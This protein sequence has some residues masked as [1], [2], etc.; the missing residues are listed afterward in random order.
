MVTFRQ[1][2]HSPQDVGRL[3]GHK[4]KYFEQ[5]N[6]LALFCV[7]YVDDGAFPFKNREQLTRGISL[8]Y[9]HFTRFALEMHVGRGE[10][11]SKTKCIFFPPSGFFS[12]K[13]IMP[14]VNGM[15]RKKLSVPKGKN[16][17][18][19]YASRHK[20]EQK[21][22]DDLPETQLIVVCDGFVTFCRHLNYL[23]NWISFSL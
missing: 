13:I 23:G 9:S 17:R 3:T 6:L 4:K 1:H 12:W 11:F 2:T 10:K 5:G 18:E 16:K 14:A 8:I 21:E 19:S 7:F 15:S 22:Y 20:G